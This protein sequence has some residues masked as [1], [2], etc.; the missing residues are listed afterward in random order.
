M[1][2]PPNELS[3]PLQ[4]LWWLKQGNLAMGPEWQKAHE[5]CQTSEGTHAYDLVHALANWIEGDTGNASYWYRR[6]GEQRAATIETE[7]Q[8]ISIELSK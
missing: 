6:V 4:A 7:W 3:L 5:I 8:G 1:A 2:Q